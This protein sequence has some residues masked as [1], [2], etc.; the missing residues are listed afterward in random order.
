[1]L[2]TAM[3]SRT[4]FRQFATGI[5]CCVC[6][7]TG[8]ASASGQEPASKAK[9]R[10]SDAQQQDKSET[11][12]ST[13]DELFKKLTGGDASQSNRQENPLEE[14]IRGMREAQKRIGGKDT[15]LKTRELQQDIVKNLE[16]LIEAIRQQAQSRSSSGN[17]PKP[18]S[19]D[20]REQSSEP[21]ETSPGDNGPTNKDKSP[22][23]TDK[24]RDAEN[25]KIAPLTS[26]R[27]DKEVWGHLPEKLRQKL[28]N[29]YQDKYLPKYDDL[30]RRYFESLAEE[31]RP[32]PLKK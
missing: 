14:A 13:D 4:G 27:M 32:A 8:L 18:Q 29:V 10:T 28:R 23:S 3:R 21:S 7:V 24:L 26:K 2:Q 17:S 9:G 30:V 20:T 6:V 11:G 31:G 15:G 22:E 5:L 16:Q 25:R 19:D 12:S 1:M